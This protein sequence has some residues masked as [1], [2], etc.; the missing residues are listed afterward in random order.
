MKGCENLNF[1]VLFND[2]FSSNLFEY[3]YNKIKR[4]NLYVKLINNEIVVFITY[5]KCSSIRKDKKAF[6]IK[7][8]AQSIYSPELSVERFEISSINLSNIQSFYDNIN[9]KEIGWDRFEYDNDTICKTLENALKY[10]ISVG[11]NELNT[12]YNINDYVSFLKKYRIDL[13]KYADKLYNDSP[14]LI[15]IDDHDDF[16]SVSNLMIESMLR[17]FDNDRNNPIFIEASKNVRDTI[18]NDLIIPRDNVY[19]N[20]ELFT[21]TIHELKKRKKANLE[22]LSK[23]GIAY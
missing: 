18:Q 15:M 2:L 13:L 11:V 16:T 3:G 19:K 14:L 1:N 21:L 5:Q 10:T 22:L 6:F 17:N 7:I 23:H 4:H 12:I 8:G 20:P 9:N